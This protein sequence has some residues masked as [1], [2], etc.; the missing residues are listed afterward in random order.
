MSKL[1][2]T[3]PKHSTVMLI[4]DL[5]SNAIKTPSD[6][7]AFRMNRKE[8]ELAEEYK[9]NLSRLLEG[10]IKKEIKRLHKKQTV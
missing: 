9:L 7:I 4:L 1:K 5:E 10:A 6:V 3:T 8:K 2:I